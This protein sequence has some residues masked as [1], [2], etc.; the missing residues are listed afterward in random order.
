METKTKSIGIASG[1]CRP[2]FLQ[3]LLSAIEDY[4]AKNNASIDVETVSLA[5]KKPDDSATELVKEG[6]VKCR[7]FEEALYLSDKGVDVVA[8]PNFKCLNFL[9]EVQTE[10]TTPIVGIGQAI[11]EGFKGKDG[12][13]VGYL[14][15]PEAAKYKNVTKCFEG[16]ANVEWIVADKD[17]IELID[18]FFYIASNKDCTENEARTACALLATACANLVSKGAEIILPTCLHQISFADELENKGYDVFNVPAA[19]ANYLCSR[20][21][22]DLPKPFKLG[23]VGGLGPLATVDLYNKITK[24]TPA[25]ND[26]EHFKI[27]IEQN[28]QIADRTKYLLYGGEDPTLALYAACKKLEKDQVDAIVFPCN[29]AHA[30][31]DTIAPHISV[32]FINMQQ[33]TME[34]IKEKFGPN[35][36]VGLMATDGTCKTGIYE[37]KANKLGLKFVKPD[38]EPQKCVMEA[39]YGEKG[40]KAGYT[41]GFCREQLLKAAQHLVE[42]KGATVLILGCTELPLILDE[43]DN[44]DI[45]GHKVGIVDPTSVVAR[46]AVAMAARITKERGR[47]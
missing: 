39:I 16:V 22:A 5:W 1:Q 27:A 10:I 47:R 34:E 30:Y 20:D 33:V 28:P 24:F 13:K 46:R 6:D 25:K 40:V 42:D 19:F 36:V 17:E 2:Q 21:W 7:T 35:A 8:V 29:T 11:A 23:I 43:D 41:D 45:N 3:L 37:V 26:Q 9:G 15:D 38:A 44:F 14:G 32:P 31:L 12:L 4:K 18:K